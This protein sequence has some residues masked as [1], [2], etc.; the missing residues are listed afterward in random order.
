MFEP[1]L[2]P[3]RMRPKQGVEQ[4]RKHRAAVVEGAEF[5]RAPA[6]DNLERRFEAGDVPARVSFRVFITRREIEPPVTVQ[7][8]QQMLQ[9]AFV[10]QA[11]DRPRNL[12]SGGGSIPEDSHE[13]VFSG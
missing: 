8:P 7:F 2:V 3:M 6:A 10:R 5:E 1:K 13:S 4:A 9:P 11:G 12:D